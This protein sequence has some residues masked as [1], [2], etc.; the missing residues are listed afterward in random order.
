[1]STVKEFA[2][3]ALLPDSPECGECVQ[4]LGESLGALYG[5]ENVV[6]DVG[7]GRVSVTY[8]P[9]V[10]GVELLVEAASRAGV[11][12]ASRLEH[13]TYALSG[14]DCPD[15]AA[16]IEKTVA[17]VQG[18]TFANLNFAAGTM[19]VEWDPEKDPRAELEALVRR[20]GHGIEPVE[21]GGAARAAAERQGWDAG[22]YLTAAAGAAIL[23]GWSFGLLG[24]DAPATW[25]FVAATALGL[26]RAGR[27]ALVSL[28][29]RNVDMNVLISVAVLGAAALGEW[30]EAAVVLFLYHL[31]L[32]LENRSLART[33][34]A[35][36]DLLAL[37][38]DTA[39]VL[40]D[41]A[42]VEV[43]VAAI[44]PGD[45][46]VVRPGERVP[47]DGEVVAG[48]T[49]MDESAVTGESVPVEK[50]PG[51]GVFSGSLNTSGLVRIRATAP[52]SGSAV[53]RIVSMVEEA[54]AR[55]APAE[56]AIDRFSRYYT[57]AAIGLAAAVAVLP[58]LVGPLLGLE[59]GTLTDWFYRGLVVLVV[60]CP[61]ALVISTPVS[62]VSGITACSRAGVLVKGGVF[63]ERAAR[64]DAVGLDKTGTLSEGRPRL[65]RVM[66]LDEAFS[67]AEA[68]GIAGALEAGS[69]HPLARAIVEAAGEH[70]ARKRV[71]SLHELPGVGVRGRVDGQEFIVGSA[72]AAREQG[73]PYHSVASAVEKVEAE[74]LTPV[75]LATGSN[76]VGVF[77]LGDTVRE[78]AGAAV[79][80]LKDAGVR[81]IVML[82]GDSEAA[83]SRVARAVSISDVR[84]RL[85]PEEK[86]GFVEE[87]RE[88]YGT[89]AMVGDGVN[90]APALAAA[91]IGVAMG[92]GGAD[93]AVE[94]AD[95]TL[96]RDD[97]SA[98]AD[99][100]L[101][102]RATMRN[103]AQN[104]AFAIFVKVAVLV[105]AV[106]GKATMWMAVFADTGVALL[107]ILNALRLLRQPGGNPG[108]P[109]ARASRTPD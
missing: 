101:I 20:M 79:G 104:V 85:M 5:V 26:V 53:A 44:V 25:A 37:T 2:I 13:T 65:E 30:S 38:P 91:D 81:H 84:A 64:V 39:T 45:E 41:G 34:R 62:I 63:L 86:T 54:Q 9:E 69:R 16:G 6:V 90:D 102:G 28:A 73:V 107:V 76:A 103:I 27:R 31:G 75:V 100:V 57:P 52:A 12:V 93:T 14:L 18:V 80:S 77:G 71:E 43:D 47:V 3:P 15:C 8:D 70:A 60:A 109:Q 88:R 95:V 94:T 51:D 66:L 67:E 7:A 87:L 11:A 89:V 48:E 4:K 59:P 78:D 74:G 22:D 23:V 99:F 55:K 58:P 106:L 105:L 10:I 40:R 46:V 24:A 92:L 29:A 32:A 96:V 56:R 108:R 36:S 1:M 50:S 35:I 72:E 49:A 61:C 68:L 42:E 19:L 82:T 97:L 21:S 98:L 17:A 33:R 83:A